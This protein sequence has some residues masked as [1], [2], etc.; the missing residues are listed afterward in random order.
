MNRTKYT[1]SKVARWSCLALLLGGCGSLAGID[2]DDLAT[3]LAALTRGSVDFTIHTDDAC[4]NGCVG[5]PNGTCDAAENNFVCAQDCACGDGQC[6]GTE[7]AENCPVDCKY[8]PNDTNDE[9][10]FCGNNRCETWEHDHLGLECD[11]DCHAG[12]DPIGT[13]CGNDLC[14]PGETSAS[15]KAD[16]GNTSTCGDHS[17]AP[18]AGETFATCDADCTNFNVPAGRFV[19]TYCSGYDLYSRYSD[20]NGGFVDHLVSELAGG[21]D[22]TVSDTAYPWKLITTAPSTCNGA[23][24]LK[25]NGTPCTITAA[26]CNTDASWATLGTDYEMASDPNKCGTYRWHNGT[27][28]PVEWAKVGMKDCTQGGCVVHQCGGQSNTVTTGTRATWRPQ[29]ARW[30]I[31]ANKCQ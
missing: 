29:L 21:C 30:S 27:F 4:V 20:G 9:N 31:Y 23:Q 10:D 16:C 7:T 13:T 1:I 11:A 5:A 8:G 6:S 28:Q 12:P 14:E 26:N 18:T 19:G 3:S 17:C 22:P 2:S 24:L 15:C 25:P